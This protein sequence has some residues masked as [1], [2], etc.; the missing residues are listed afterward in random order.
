MEFNFPRIFFNPCKHWCSHR[1][2]RFMYTEKGLHRELRV[3]YCYICALQ[4]CDKDPLSFL[5]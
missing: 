5:Q 1:Y 4:E 2:F 3:K